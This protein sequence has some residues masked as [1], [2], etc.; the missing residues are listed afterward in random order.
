MDIL[1]VPVDTT[2]EEGLTALH[3]AASNGHTVAV[4]IGWTI[5]VDLHAPSSVWSAP[6]EAGGR[7]LAQ[8][9]LLVLLLPALQGGVVGNGGHD[10]GPFPSEWLSSS[11]YLRQL[12]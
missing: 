9:G 7:L 5:E 2:N 12:F 8:R 6:A 10:S 3:T 11:P 1:A 4:G